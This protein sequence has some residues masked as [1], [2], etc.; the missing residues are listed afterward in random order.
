MKL[1]AKAYRERIGEK[2]DEAKAILAKAEA[3]ERD[4][5][6]AEKKAFDAVAAEIDS[7]K[8]DLARADRVE[9]EEARLASARIDE[10]IRARGGMVGGGLGD[11]T[12]VIAPPPGSVTAKD[13]QQVYCLTPAQ[14]L[15]D[16]PGGHDYDDVPYAFGQCVVAAATGD[17]KRIP[18]SLRNAL[19]ESV[20][21]LGGVMVPEEIARR[22]IDAARARSVLIRAGALTQPMASDRETIA[23]VATDPTFETHAENATITE[24]DIVFDAVGLTARTI[25]TV[26]RA[27]RELVEDAGNMARVIEDTITRALAVELDRQMLVG[28]GSAEMTGILLTPGIGST[29]SIGAIAWADLLAAQVAIQALNHE[30]NGYIVSPTIAGDLNALTSG[31]GT[32]SAALWQ[33]PPPGV[34]D[35]A[36]FVTS[37]MPDTDILVGDFAQTILGLRQNALV[38]FTSVGGDAFTKHSV[39]FKVT[40]RGDVALEHAAAF[41]VL[42]GITT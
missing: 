31:D 29:G 18:R 22:I 9:A 10:R 16:L 28:S 36:R 21:T 15:A 2:H 5:T 6:A 37:N 27:S 35:L 11:G 1:T 7:L 14:R 8:G 19:S 41:H 17:W 12:G 3:E 23:R 30:P 13:G 39:L 34:A 38:E 25:G 24:R 20:N 26:V 42:S 32:N 33:G 4:L 40:W